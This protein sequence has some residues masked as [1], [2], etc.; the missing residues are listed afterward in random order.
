MK[1]DFKFSNLCG[2]VYHKGNLVF[3]PDGNSVLSPVGNRVTLFDLVNNKTETLPFENKRDIRR[4]AL[5]PNGHLLLSVDDLGN[6]LLVNF[7]RRTVLHHFNFKDKVRDIQFSPDGKY[8]AVGL[9]RKIEVWRSPGYTREFAPFELHRR[10][11]GHYDDITQISW[12]PD[13]RFF[14]TSSKDM[15]TKIYSVDP[16]EGFT[17]TTLT[18]HRYAVVGSWFTNDMRAI[19]TVSRDG[20]VCVRRFREHMVD[21]NLV[22]GEFPRDEEGNFVRTV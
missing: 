22:F 16:I 2:T 6:T 5:S 17:P 8:F 19:Y 3:T 4:L 11:G 10:Y 1:T 9:G 15:A 20:A 7:R 12:S 14:L 21:E 18:G 13:S